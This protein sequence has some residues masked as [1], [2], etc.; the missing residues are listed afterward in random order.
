MMKTICRYRHLDLGHYTVLRALTYPR[1]MFLS[2]NKRN[3]KY[4]IIV[5]DRCCT[6]Y[7][8]MTDKHNWQSMAQLLILILHTVIMKFYAIWN[9]VSNPLVFKQKMRL[10]SIYLSLSYLYDISEHIW[11]L[12]PVAQQLN[13]PTTFDC[14]FW[15]LCRY[16]NQQTTLFNCEMYRN[17]YRY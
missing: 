4:D 6:R 2:K 8:I 16:W 12:H 5:T 14:N 15:S 13:F 3:A 9:L 1:I 7:I 11:K 10:L 17:I